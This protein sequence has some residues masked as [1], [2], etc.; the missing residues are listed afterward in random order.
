MSIEAINYAVPTPG[1]FIKEELEAREWTQGDLAYVLGT[2]PQNLH[3][4]LS[5]K[6][7]ISSAMAKALGKA[8]DVPAIFFTNLQAAYDLSIADDPD[9]AI[10]RRARLQD[11]FPVREMIK[12]GWIDENLD[13]S[14]LEEHMMRYFRCNSVDDIPY[15]SHAARKSSYYEDRNISP[16]QISW[17]FRVHQ[18]AEQIELPRYSATKLRKALEDLKGLM[19]APEET[20]NAP[21]V[22]MECG[23]RI[24][25]VEALPNAKI[26]GACFWLDKSSPVIG[27]SLRFDRIDNFWFVLRHEI[28]H[29]L[30]CDGQK[31][32][33]EIIDDM[34]AMSSN[35]SLPDEELKANI[36]AQEFCVPR[37]KL[38]GF[39]ARKNPYFSE[40]DISGFARVH[41]VHPG[42][43]VGQIHDY[44]KNFKLLRKHL[45]KVRQFVTSTGM[46]DGWGDVFPVSL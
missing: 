35:A 6:R 16:I 34:E 29:V 41:G 27:M 46:F 20:R 45:V 14:L 18:I 28:E 17:L 12:R 13:A 11:H 32:G 40:H 8:L 7:G 37:D 44:T 10:E 25:F 36:A 15:L 30:N 3:A 4:I 23:V 1:E 19:I 31:K 24:I 22:L 5:G 26:D 2:S 21:R 43:V 39:I 38:V 33:Q 42:I 9:P